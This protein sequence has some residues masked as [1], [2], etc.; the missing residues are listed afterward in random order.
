MQ[1][2]YDHFSWSGRRGMAMAVFLIGSNITIG[3]IKKKNG[4]KQFHSWYRAVDVNFH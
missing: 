1:S 3:E 4:F 2:S